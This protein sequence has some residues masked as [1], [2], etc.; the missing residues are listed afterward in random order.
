VKPAEQRWAAY[1]DDTD[2]GLLTGGTLLHTDFNP[3]NVLMTAHGA[4]VI[5]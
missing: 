2:L 4:W 5:D 1:V 3:L